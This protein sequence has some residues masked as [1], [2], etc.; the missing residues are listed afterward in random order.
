MLS[1]AT[2]II[3]LL[4]G[5][6]PEILKY[7]KA[8]QDNKQEL[9]IL[10]MQ[11]DLQAQGHA[12]KMEEIST[13]AD[14]SESSALY[15][16]AEI[17]LTGVKWVDALIEGINSLVRPVITYAFLGFYAA[18]KFEYTT[19]P[20]DEFDQSTLTLVLGYWFGQRAAKWAFGKK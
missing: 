5:F 2:A 15:K 4:G 10:K 11:A 3:G 19:K 17:Q 6:F 14:I 8:K 7:F 16:S 13:N 1:I 9:A 18:H 12:E 20:F